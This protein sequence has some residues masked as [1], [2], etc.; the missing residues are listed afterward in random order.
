VYTVNIF[1]EKEM[2]MI[3]IKKITKM[4]YKDAIPKMK[5]LMEKHNLSI[6]NVKNLMVIAQNFNYS[7]AISEPIE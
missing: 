6:M 4:P 5:E 2:N 7:M 3:E 1:K